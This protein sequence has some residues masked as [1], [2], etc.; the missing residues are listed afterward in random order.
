MTVKI[1]DLK[2]NGVTVPNGS[3]IDMGTNS[4]INVTF[5]VDLAKASSYTIGPAKVWISVFRSSGSRKDYY[6][7][8]VPENEFI[9]GAS[10]GYNFNILDSEI[11]F[12]S[13]NYLMATLKQD[14][15]PGSEW[16]SQQIPI[17]KTPAFELTPSSLSIACGD[18][19]P[20]T[21]TVINSSNLNGVT[22]QWSIG[23]GWSGNVGNG[24]S[25]TLTPNSGTILPSNISVTP[26][27]NGQNLS[28]LT[29]NISRASFSSSATITG[30]NVLCSTETYTINN[31]PNDVSIK[32]VSSSDNNIATAT[33]DSNGLITATEVAN[34]IF[35]LSV[36]L[37][38]SCSQTI[39]KTKSIQVGENANVDITGLENGIDAGS[40]VM[41]ELTNNNGCGQIYFTSATNATFLSVGHDYA[42]LNVDSN[43]VGNGSIY[44]S[45]TGTN[46]IYKEFPINSE[47]II[48]PN[49]PIENY[50]SVSRIQND[51]NVYPYNQWKMVKA[52][53]YSSST[54]VDYWEWNIGNSYYTKP[55]DTSIIFLPFESSNVNVS[56]RACNS[57]GC[58][59]FVSTV[60]N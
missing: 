20:K 49:P 41:I 22:Y 48:P 31:L 21:F 47:P 55:N 30:S 24:N 9:T 29:R 44:V 37:Q 4:S 40:T 34:G 60:I 16:N 33:L 3:S 2:A 36:V 18:T 59:Q 27:Y 58:S 14:G 25:I 43:A 57:D 13:G 50:I 12:G 54:N 52:Y 56:V 8:A 19:S 53:Y 32:S 42:Y 46:S 26:I 51:Y 11:D 23:S 45:I 5:I 35:M 6:I 7:N 28:T 15:Q 1:A 38:N 39:T 10:K 17:V